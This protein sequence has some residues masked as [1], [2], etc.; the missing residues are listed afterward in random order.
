GRTYLANGHTIERYGND[1][2]PRSKSDIDTGVKK[3]YEDKILIENKAQDTLQNFAFIINKYLDSANN[4]SEVGLLGIGFHAKDTYNGSG[5]GR[6]EV[7]A[8]I[9]GIK[10]KVFSAEDVVRELIAE[11]RGKGSSV[12]EQLL[13]LADLST[14]HE[15]SQMKSIQEN[16]LIDGLRSGEWMKALPFLQN[17]D[18][19]REMILKSEYAVSEL[20]KQSGVPKETLEKM[21]STELLDAISKIKIQGTPEEYG[22]IKAAIF[23]VFSSMK[24]EKG[25]DYLA[26]YGKGTIPSS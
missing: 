5:V 17:P 10:G 7:L 15:V 26:K 4:N 24:D 9:F 20:Q 25:T 22:T 16:L 2:K 19:I 18:R 12:R 13:R 11:K 14:H 21:S 23:E 8:D 1:G 6:L 3:A